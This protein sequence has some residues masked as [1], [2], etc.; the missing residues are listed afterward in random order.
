MPVKITSCQLC[1]PDVHN[2]FKRKGIPFT[3]KH[4]GGGKTKTEVNI[5]SPSTWQE[6][7]LAKMCWNKIQFTYHNAHRNGDSIKC[8]N[9]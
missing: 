1:T 6:G 3:S 4:I 7:S 5:T 8:L 2:F 9:C